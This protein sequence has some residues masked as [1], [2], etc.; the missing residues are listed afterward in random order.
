MA[1]IVP[2][3]KKAKVTELNDYRPIAL[4]SVIT[5]CFERL[6]KDHITSTLPDTLD[7]LQFSYCPKRSTDCLSYPDKRNT[8]VRMLFIDYSSAFNTIVPSKLVIKLETLGLDPTLCNWVLDFLTGR[9]QVVRVGNIF[10][11]L[12]LNTG[13]PQGCVLS[14]LLYSLFTLDCVAMHASNSIIKFADDTSGRLDYQQR[15]D[16]LQGGGEGPRS[17]M[18]GKQ[19]LTQRQQNK[20]NYWGLQETAEGTAPHPHRRDSSVESGTLRFS[21]YTSQTN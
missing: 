17:V 16:G 9:P 15:R 11:P 18:S 6:V 1:T 13:A 2:V 10:T 21:A 4:T 14:P 8:Y 5:K 20:G 19:P 12:I 3:P 7:P